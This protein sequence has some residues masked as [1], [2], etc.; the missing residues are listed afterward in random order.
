VGLSTMGWNALYI[1][2][3]AEVTEHRVATVVGAGTM[4]NFAGMLLITPVFGAVADAAHSYAPAWVALAAW[5]ALGTVLATRIRERRGTAR[6]A[7]SDSRMASSTRK[8][9]T[10]PGTRMPAAAVWA[11]DQG[12]AKRSPR[13]RART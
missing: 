9:P 13:S 8:S 12:S 10:E 5:C 2:L 11:S 7:P 3:A 1:T 6:A 4:V